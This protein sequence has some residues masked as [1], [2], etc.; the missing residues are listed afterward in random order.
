MTSTDSATSPLGLSMEFQVSNPLHSKE[1]VTH[2]I[3]SFVK[4]YR[5]TSFSHP[6]P[7]FHTECTKES[8]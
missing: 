2:D 8:M 7:S 5:S 1:T 6:P 3:I 4:Y